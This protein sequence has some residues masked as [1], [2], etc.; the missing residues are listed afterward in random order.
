MRIISCELY[1]CLR[2]KAK[3]ISKIKITFN[4]I[5]QI[6]IG[7]NG[8]GKSS[9]LRELSPLPPS[10]DE[11][12]K[13]GY[14][15][16]FIEHNKSVY[17]LMSHTG[18][19]SRHSFIRDGVEL[20]DSKT[21]NAQKILVKDHFGYTQE[22]HDL[23]LGLVDGVSFTKMSPSDRR[24]WMMALYPSDLTFVST[25]HEVMKTMLRD[26]KGG[27]RTGTKHLAELYAQRKKDVTIDGVQ[28]SLD[29]L[30]QR[31]DRISRLVT[32]HIDRTNYQ[33]EI[34]RRRARITQLA[35][36]NAVRCGGVSGKYPSRDAAVERLAQY[37]AELSQLDYAYNTHT[38]ELQELTSSEAFKSTGSEE[39][40]K[41]L[42][43]QRDEL[44]TRIAKESAHVSSA[45]P[46][47]TTDPVW[48]FVM[49]LSDETIRK[50]MGS[51]RT[52]CEALMAIPAMD[53]HSVTVPR[54]KAALNAQYALSVERDKAVDAMARADHRYKH[55]INGDRTECPSCHHQWMPGISQQDIDTA[56]QNVDTTSAQ[57]EALER[58]LLNAKEYLYKYG[59]WYNAVVKFLAVVDAQPELSEVYGWLDSQDVLYTNA[60]QIAATLPSVV[61]FAVHRCRLL[62]YQRTLANV[63]ESLK[64][65]SSDAMEWYKRR[66]AE[67]EAAL[68][69]V[70]EKRRH[71]RK[72]I[73]SI[74]T[75]IAI[76]DKAIATS[77]ELIT[78]KSEITECVTKQAWQTV[79]L[80]ANKEY[81]FITE[82]QRAE[83][84]VLYSLRSLEGSISSTEHHLDEMKHAKASLDMFTTATSPI[85]GMVAE[86][87]SS[88]IACFIGNMNAYI[89]EMWDGLLQIR[90]CSI[91]DGALSFKFPVK[92]GTGKIETKDV[93]Q[94]STGETQIINFAFRLVVFR[95]LGFEHYP[96]H[97][98][99][100]GANF[101]E[102]QRTKLMSFV[103]RLSTSG[104][105]SQL[106]MI[107]HYI[108][109]HGALI[110]AEV[111]ALSSDGVTLPEKYNEH[112]ILE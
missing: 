83:T 91:E 9:L 22:I 96:L 92:T 78:L 27:L 66:Y 90:P 76:I 43:S 5:V 34:E 20:N 86:Q 15:H 18:S 81:Q 110:N 36:A 39:D 45:P 21:L 70:I 105:F 12:G 58:R 88:F 13:G 112:V 31:R 16:C 2:I 14:K 54:Y 80:A 37:Q 59:D 17:E 26:N 1:N 6:I 47:H 51:Y 35:T 106:F 77:D 82:Q 44:I 102:T 79:A 28:A 55:L 100:V 57:A 63:E 24:E 103:K 84:S 95:Y 104:E 111:T 73:E 72:L 68:N 93:A 46:E 7:K 48:V 3:G 11:Y 52:L 107:S 40:K 69:D 30:Q 108:A 29:N 4:K 10:N 74:T 97:M 101:D 71:C 94:S 89:E 56:K 67:H 19:P 87:L 62:Y 85:K 75:D 25:L 42:E 65:F 23:L 64:L 109:Q 8:S 53:D 50:L 41:R 33:H 38:K 98:D 61:E 32:D 49:S 60:K 99:E